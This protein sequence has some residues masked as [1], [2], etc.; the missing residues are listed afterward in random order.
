MKRKQIIGFAIE[1]IAGA[2]EH[3]ECIVII[4][5]YLASCINTGYPIHENIEHSDGDKE[6]VKGEI[7]EYKNGMLGIKFHITKFSIF[8]IVKTAAVEKSSACE[9]ITISS[10]SNAVISGKKIT[11]TVENSTTSL[12]LQVAVSDKG[13]YNIYSD[14]ACKK[15]LTNHKLQLKVGVNKV[16][17]KVTAEDGTTS[18]SYTLTITRQKAPKKVIIVAT[19]YDFT[20]AFAGGVLAGQLGGKVICT[21]ISEKDAKKMVSYIK[22]NYSKR[23]EIYIIGMGQAVNVDLNKM[24]K[25]EGYTNIVNIGGEDKYET[26]KLI[27]DNIKLPDETKVVLVSGEFKPKDADNIQKICAELGYPILFVETDSLTTYTIEAL[28]ES[29]P[30]QIYIVGDKTKIS[31]KVVEE[32]VKEIGMDKSDIIRISTGKEI[33]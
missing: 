28:K 30:T 6:L 11:T 10:L 14:K 16:Y 3:N 32:I 4:G 12:K 1:V 18:K 17:I 20:D 2:G 15:E 31:S 21:G 25:K 26:A 8:T 24:L 9:V 27:A 7:V 33:K 23:D 29:N 13:L 19:K 22:K 5:T